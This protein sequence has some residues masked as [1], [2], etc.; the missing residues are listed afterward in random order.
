MNSDRL[1]YFSGSADKMPGKG[2]NE[3]I[4]DPNKYVKL[5][6]IPNWR[7]MLSNF[8]VAPFEVLSVRWNSVEHMFQSYKINIVNPQLAWTFSL[9]SQSPLSLGDGSVAQKNRKAAILSSDQIKQWD[10]MKDSVLYAALKGKFTQHPEL[11]ELL[12]ATN[13]AELWH[14]AARTPASRQFLLERVRSEL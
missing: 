9:N 14:G 10:E 6:K 13:N 2:A 8:Y 1:Y 11:R 3:Y 5:G 4:T 7:K 12:L